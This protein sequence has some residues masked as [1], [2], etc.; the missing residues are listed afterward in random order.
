MISPSRLVATQESQNNL[1]RQKK[2]LLAVNLQIHNL[3]RLACLMCRSDDA[4][5]GEQLFHPYPAFSPQAPRLPSTASQVRTHG[6]TSL[7]LLQ[8]VS[9]PSGTCPRVGAQKV[10]PVQRPYV[11]TN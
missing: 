3:L 10:C 4:A 6:S 9:L 7:A 11:N 8:R 1:D 2:F 5:K